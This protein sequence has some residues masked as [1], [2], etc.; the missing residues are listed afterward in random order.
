MALSKITVVYMDRGGPYTFHVFGGIILP[1]TH[2]GSGVSALYVGNSE[3]ECITKM[4]ATKLVGMN[5][6]NRVAVYKYDSY[7]IKAHEIAKFIQLK[8]G[9]DPAIEKYFQKNRPYMTKLYGV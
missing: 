2:C 9:G 5:T 3:E 4:L 1:I 7:S 8:E 6:H